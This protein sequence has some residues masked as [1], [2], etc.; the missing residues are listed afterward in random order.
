M[1]S[2]GNSILLLI[3]N[4]NVIT[5]HIAKDCG[6]LAVPLNGSTAGR[7]TT[8]PNTIT[9]SCHEGFLLNGSTVRRCQADGSWSGTETSCEG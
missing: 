9:F 7:K 8:F 4:F 2:L 5:Y 3:L 1:G 6:A